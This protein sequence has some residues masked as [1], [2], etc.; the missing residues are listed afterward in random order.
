MFKRK[1]FSYSLYEYLASYLRCCKS[2]KLEE[3]HKHRRKQ[4]DLGMQL[5]QKDL[6]L[7][8]L[9]KNTKKFKIM[10]KLLI[11]KRQKAL[12]TFSQ[13]FMLHQHKTENLL[14][15]EVTRFF[16]AY[17]ALKKTAINAKN[18]PMDKIVMN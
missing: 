15:K 18:N 11:D 2:T 12:L 5:V 7:V 13:I 3:K 10:L 16:R 14:G 17:A 4:F 1:F 9:I 6:D 8:K